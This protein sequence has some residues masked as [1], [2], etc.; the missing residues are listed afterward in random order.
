M[1]LSHLVVLIATAATTSATTSIAYAE[2]AEVEEGPPPDFAVAP[3]PPAVQPVQVILP[4]EIKLKPRVPTKFVAIPR[5]SLTYV[6]AVQDHLIGSNFAVDLMAARGNLEVGLTL[7]VDAGQTLT[8]L[9]FVWPQWG[10]TMR[11][12][13]ADSRVR[14]GFG[15]DLGFLVFLRVTDPGG[16]M[17]AFSMSPRFD[18]AVD[19]ARWSQGRALLLT[20]RAGFSALLGADDIPAGSVSAGLGVRL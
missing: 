18:A 4:P 11:W 7:Q 10:V 9:T 12:Q 8:S 17:T 19:L 6:N 13:I 5:L 2:P 16:T 15:F 3:P 1:R 20:V 14:L